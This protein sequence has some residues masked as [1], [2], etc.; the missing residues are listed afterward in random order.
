MLLRRPREIFGAFTAQ[1][2][3]AMQQFKPELIILSAGF[4]SRIDDPLGGF[5]LTDAD[6]NDLTRLM[7]D[8][9]NEHSG[10]RLISML[11]GGYN[12]DGLGKAA[13][14]HAKALMR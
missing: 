12:L 13:A 1:L 14:A 9:A 11:E 7:L 6:F 3:P 2:I 5:T 4:D 8:L 10:G